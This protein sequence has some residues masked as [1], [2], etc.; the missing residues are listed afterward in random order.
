MKEWQQR[1]LDPVY[2]VVW[3][4]GIVVKVRQNGNW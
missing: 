1:P 2:Y 3:M 4:D